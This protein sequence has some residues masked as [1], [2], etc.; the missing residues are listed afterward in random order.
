MGE[1]PSGTEAAAHLRLG[2]L[3]ASRKVQSADERPDGSG[4]QERLG[5]SHRDAHAIPQP[6]AAPFRV[7]T[8][9]SRPG[10]LSTPGAGEDAD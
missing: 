2:W 8:A 1:V 6:P 5:T 3:P 9:N 7:G 10:R 4:V